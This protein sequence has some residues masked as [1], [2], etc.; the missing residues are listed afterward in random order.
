[1]LP[2]SNGRIRPD[3]KL[4]QRPQMQAIMG[5]IAT[6]TVYDDPDLLALCIWLSPGA[7]RW[8]EREILELRDRRV[9]ESGERGADVRAKVEQRKARR[10]TRAGQRAKAK[11]KAKV[12]EADAR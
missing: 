3:D 8:I 2:E 10:R 7:V 12:A 4:I 9:A 5:D 6:S 11:Q 1:M